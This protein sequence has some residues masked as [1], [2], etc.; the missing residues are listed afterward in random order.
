MSLR[1]TIKIHTYTSSSFY[2]L[3]E[4]S[5][6]NFYSFFFSPK[7]FSPP[8]PVPFPAKNGQSKVQEQSS[9]TKSKVWFSISRNTS[10]VIH[11]LLLKPKTYSFVCFSQE[12]WIMGRFSVWKWRV[13]CIIYFTVALCCM[14]QSY[15]F[16]NLIDYDIDSF[17]GWKPSCLMYDFWFSFLIQKINIF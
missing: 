14:T 16:K 2:L 17:K 15:F 9:T 1:P 13:K 11:L 7:F 10:I 8:I 12:Y 4:C 3:E 6:K 5:N